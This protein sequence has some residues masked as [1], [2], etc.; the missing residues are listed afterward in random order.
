MESSTFILALLIVMVA[1]YKTIRRRLNA[2]QATVRDLLKRHHF[3]VRTGVPPEEALLRVLLN[4]RRWRD[5][6]SRFLAELIAR[7]GTKENVFRFVSLAEGYKFDRERLPAIAAA[8]D[9]ASAMHEIAVWLVDFGRRMQQE[10]RLKEAEFVQKLA[11]CLEP[12]RYFTK[13][14]LGSTYYKMENYLEALPL[15]ESGLAGIDA[16]PGSGG[17]QAGIDE[18]RASYLG[19]YAACVEKNPCAA[20]GEGSA[21]ELSPP[22]ETRRSR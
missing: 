12:D 16:S 15:L 21:A 22:N 17:I 6:S 11:L 10:N 18:N 9:S 8:T 7:L 13:L 20:I 3:Y 4:R 1:V 5:F 2:P 19:M 14:A